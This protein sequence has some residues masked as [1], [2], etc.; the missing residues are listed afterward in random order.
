VLFAEWDQ[1][2]SLRSPSDRLLNFDESSSAELDY[3]TVHKPGKDDRDQFQ[4]IHCCTSR[5]HVRS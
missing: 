5:T 1:R 2:A 4:R 3:A